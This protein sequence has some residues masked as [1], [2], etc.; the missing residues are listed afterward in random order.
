MRLRLSFEHDERTYS[1]RENSALRNTLYS[2]AYA[3]LSGQP[4]AWED[5]NVPEMKR[6]EGSSP[7]AP[8]CS[9]GPVDGYLEK[10]R[11]RPLERRTT[12]SDTTAL[13]AIRSKVAQSEQKRPV[14]IEIARLGRIQRPEL[15][16]HGHPWEK[17]A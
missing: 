7:T 9:S 3:V 12:S 17:D 14:A 5:V 1:R 13:K 4:I 10:R 11:E 6:R 16:Y 2:L 8:V 15:Q